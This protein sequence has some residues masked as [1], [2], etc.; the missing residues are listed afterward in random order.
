MI[1]I[2]CTNC[3]SVL[4]I[5]DAFAGGV[6]RCQFCGTIQTVPSKSEAALQPVGSIA[7]TKSLYQ[8]ENTPASRAEAS[9]TGLDD[10]AGAV[11]GSGLAGSGSGLSRD[12]SDASGADGDEISSAI[13]VAIAIHGTRFSVVAITAA[14]V[15]LTGIAVVILLSRVGDRGAGKPTG[16]S[17]VG[18]AGPVFCGITLNGNSVI[19]VLDRGNSINESFDSLKSVCYKSLKQMGPDRKFQVILW[20]NDAGSSEF[21]AGAIRNATAGAIEDCQRNFQDVVAGGSSHLGGPLREALGRRPQYIVIAT[22]KSE[23]DE[24]DIEALKGAVGVGSH[25]CIVQ[26]GS[27]ASPLFEDIAKNTAGQF[28]LISPT[29][30]RE[31]SH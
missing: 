25:I 12:R 5:D 22:A 30:F 24:D 27:T 18:L 21:P 31:L 6:C 11:A 1:S 29:D 17:S 15:V 20:D 7:K 13:P 19:F 4:T 2:T 28:K 9:G 26:L 14:V 16:T 23:L 10:L 3:Q 8:V